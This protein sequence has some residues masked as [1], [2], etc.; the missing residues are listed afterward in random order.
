MR[1]D[2]I[3]VSRKGIW[4]KKGLEV[5]PLGYQKWRRILV[6]KRGLDASAIGNEELE[7]LN[8]E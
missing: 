5:R 3:Q 4:S 8:E 1:N 2:Q 7:I 6:W